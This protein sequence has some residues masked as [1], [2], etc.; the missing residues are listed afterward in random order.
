MGGTKAQKDASRAARTRWKLKGHEVAEEKHLTQ[1]EV[2]MTM[3]KF[4]HMPKSELMSFLQDPKRTVNEILI[5]SIL[6]KA[7]QEGDYSRAEFLYNR[8]LGK[9]PDRVQV[10]GSINYELVSTLDDFTK[11]RIASDNR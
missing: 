7:I 9:V 6:A 1:N 10:T 8:I 4:M 11:K 2:I 3:S 5:G